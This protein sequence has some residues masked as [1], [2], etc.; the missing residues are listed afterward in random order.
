MIEHTGTMARLQFGPVL[1]AQRPAA[2]A[3]LAACK[4]AG[5]NA[6]LTDDIDARQLGEVRVPGRP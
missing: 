6:E 5:I 4:E 1:P 2:E 3:F